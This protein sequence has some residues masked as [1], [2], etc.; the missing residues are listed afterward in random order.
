MRWWKG[1]RDAGN[2]CRTWIPLMPLICTLKNG[3]NGKFYTNFTIMKIKNNF[4][5]PKNTKMNHQ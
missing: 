5:V 3:Y 4:A 1:T 2:G